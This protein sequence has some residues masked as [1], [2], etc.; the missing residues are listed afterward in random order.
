MTDCSQCIHSREVPIPNG[1]GRVLQCWRYPP[2]AG[3]VAVPVPPD[4][5]NPQGGVGVQIVPFRPSVQPRD[6][7]GEGRVK[8]TGL[9]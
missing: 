4:V 9:G 7:C 1:T 8:L 6:T 5:R 2:S 3:V